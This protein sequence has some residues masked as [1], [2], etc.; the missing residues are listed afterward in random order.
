MSRLHLI[1]FMVLLCVYVVYGQSVLPRDPVSALQ[2]PA[3]SHSSLVFRTY[4]PVY[5]GHVLRGR[6]QRTQPWLA[7]P[8]VT[9]FFCRNELRLEK[10][11]ALAPRFRLGSVNY[12]D[13][14]EGKK[15]IYDRYRK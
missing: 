6:E 8:G 5:Q 12:T 4:A 1:G 10:R 14:M 11:S 13:W 3:V 2:R 15:E 7:S 9:S